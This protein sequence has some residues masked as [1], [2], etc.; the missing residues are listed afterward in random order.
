MVVYSAD[1]VIFVVGG[2]E[3]EVALF[4]FNLHVQLAFF[5][6]IWTASFTKLQTILSKQQLNMIFQLVLTLIHE[7]FNK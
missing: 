4:P 5:R 2:L 3:Q 1:V 6:E 7:A